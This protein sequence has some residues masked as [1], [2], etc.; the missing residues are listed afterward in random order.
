[1]MGVFIGMSYPRCIFSAQM[2][3]GVSKNA[4]RMI[5]EVRR[6]FREIPGLMEG[7]EGGSGV[8]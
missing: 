1:M 5:E 8:R 6:Q 7:L 2:I 3:L 4:D